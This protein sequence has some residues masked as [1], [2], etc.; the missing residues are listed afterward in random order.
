MLTFRALSASPGEQ[1]QLPPPPSPPN[2]HLLHYIQTRPLRVSRDLPSTS[3]TPCQTLGAT[4]C[5]FGRGEKNN[6]ACPC[7]AALCSAPA[8]IPLPGSAAWK[9]GAG[10]EKGAEAGVRPAAGP[11]A[12]AWPLHRLRGLQVW[13]EETLA[14]A[15][16]SCLLC[17][18]ALEGALQALLVSHCSLPFSCWSTL[19]L[20]QRS[21]LPCTKPRGT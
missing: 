11:G 20:K 17:A 7:P 16:L 18:R 5:C 12:E 3:Q 13:G 2:G 10:A 8:C 6:E 21:L 14:T 1:A 4:L 9:P 15:R 19:T